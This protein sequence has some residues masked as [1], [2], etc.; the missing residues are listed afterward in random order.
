MLHG[1]RLGCVNC[2]GHVDLMVSQLWSWYDVSFLIKLLMKIS[3]GEVA[4]VNATM[5]W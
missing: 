3:I 2:Q 4:G 1:S 5:T